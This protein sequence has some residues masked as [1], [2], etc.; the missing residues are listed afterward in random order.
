MDGVI[1]DPFGPL[2]ISAGA[3][4]P[5]GQKETR[6]A[7]LIS[8]SPG[9]I[10]RKIRPSATIGTAT[11]SLANV[12][13]LGHLA[14][15]CAFRQLALNVVKSRLPGANQARNHETVVLDEIQGS[16]ALSTM[17]DAARKAATPR[18]ARA[19]GLLGLLA[20][21]IGNVIPL[22]GVLY[23]QW[24]HVP[25]ADAR[26]REDRHPWT[27]MRQ[28]EARNVRPQSISNK[29]SRPLRADGCNARRCCGGLSSAA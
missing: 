1:V 26:G 9:Q 25:V 19:L 6:Q 24:G 22:Y 17:A 3:M 23:W 15:H 20:T 2:Q 7:A 14:A 21:S 18:L 28:T 12:S 4:P 8:A 16:A 27:L 13:K 29:S 11:N 10:A 5:Q